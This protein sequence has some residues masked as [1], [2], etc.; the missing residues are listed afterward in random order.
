MEIQRPIDIDACSTWLE[1]DLGA[2]KNNLNLL[3]KLT[4]RPVMPVVKANAYGHGLIEVSKAAVEAGVGWL[5]VAR[6]EE[7]L[8]LRAAGVACKILVLGYTPPK[9]VGAAVQ[10]GISLTVYDKAVAESYADE[11]AQAGGSVSLH[12]KVDSGMG[13]LG[14]FPRD[15]VDFVRWLKG[16]RGLD[17][18]AIFTHFARADETKYATTDEQIERFDGVLKE[19][20]K[21]GIKPRLVHAANSAGTLNYPAGRYDLARCGIV[22][23][24]LQPSPDSPL[25]EGFIPA[26]SWK[27][28]LV[29]L[30]TLPPGHGVSYNFQYFTQKN[31]RIGAIAIGYADGFRRRAGNIVLVRGKRVPV[32]GAV[33]MDQCMVQLD[34]VPEARLQD[35]VVLIGRQGDEMISADELAKDWGT[36]NYE[37]L[38]GLADRVPR[39]YLK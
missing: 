20:E 9:Q 1:I 31:E 8:T 23:Y 11:A 3:T 37:V 2:I 16:Q 6:I 35:E 24:G 21:E 36:I 32:V 13:R 22:M 19:L 29:S 15:A 39:I 26:L 5:G 12:V 25:P 27:T 18:E 4:G 33:C 34:D 28:H 38:C 14:V 30:K 10:E 7:A 17:V